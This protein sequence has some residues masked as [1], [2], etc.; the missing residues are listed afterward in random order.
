MSPS[1]LRA[2]AAALALL[3]ALAAC[4]YERPSP[5]GTN[6]VQPLGRNAPPVCT[7]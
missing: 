3:V 1:P 6:C 7:N 5:V 4:A 2:A